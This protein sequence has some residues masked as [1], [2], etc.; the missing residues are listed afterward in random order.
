MRARAIGFGPHPRA[1]SR[2]QPP[3]R[4]DDPIESPFALAESVNS[5][6]ATGPFP[7]SN[8]FPPPERRDGERRYSSKQR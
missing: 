5:A 2:L 1:H 8:T 4:T 7:S 3:F 6:S